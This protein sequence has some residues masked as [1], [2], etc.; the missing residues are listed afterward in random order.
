M[1]RGRRRRS[2]RDS[3]PFPHRTGRRPDHRWDLA[4]FALITLLDGWEKHDCLGLA[5]FAW[6]KHAAGSGKG[7]VRP[8][9][10]GGVRNGNPVLASRRWHWVRSR[11]SCP[12]CNVPEPQGD[13]ALVASFA[14]VAQGREWRRCRRGKRRRVSRRAERWAMWVRWACADLSLGIVGRMFA[15]YDGNAGCQGGQARARSRP[16][17]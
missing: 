1:P 12:S 9:W 13:V 6:I 2:S 5:S 8:R 14:A 10:S 11:R 16:S 3:V 15:S 4:S 17:R 7:W